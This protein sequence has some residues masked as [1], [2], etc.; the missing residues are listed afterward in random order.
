MSI[1][2]TGMTVCLKGLKKYAWRKNLAGFF[3]IG[4]RSMTDAEV[5]KVV[6]YGISKGYENDQQIPV[7]EVVKLLG[8]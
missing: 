1:E 5:R 2:K 7:E 8:W 3:S 6:E 4:G